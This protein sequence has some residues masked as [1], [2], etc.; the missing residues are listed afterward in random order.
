[1][2]SRYDGDVQITNGFFGTSLAGQHLVD[3][4]RK[5]ND[6]R[7]VAKL[8]RHWD[9]YLQGLNDIMPVRNGTQKALFH[10]WRDRFVQSGREQFAEKFEGYGIPFTY[11]ENVL[12][13]RLSKALDMGPLYQKLDS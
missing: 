7:L 5:A 12:A 6:R 4:L 13:F 10:M 3:M 11:Y 9:Q 1:M 2:P 8:T